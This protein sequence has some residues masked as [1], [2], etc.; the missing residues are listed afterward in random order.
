MREIA[1]RTLTSDDMIDRDYLVTEVVQQGVK[2]VA[3]VG[4]ASNV[5][6]RQLRVGS[7]HRRRPFAIRRGW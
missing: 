4:E 6:R 3:D 1:V 2:D 7:A 5:P